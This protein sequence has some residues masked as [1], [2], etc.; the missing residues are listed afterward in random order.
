MLDLAPLGDR[1]QPST[2]GVDPLPPWRLRARVGVPGAWEYQEG[3]RQAADQLAGALAVAGRSP[4]QLRSVL[5]FG[6]GAGRV[7]PHFAARAPASDCVGCDVDQ[8]AIGWAVKWRPAQ[9]WLLSSFAPPLALEADG[10]DL[11]YSISVFSHLDRAAQDQWVEEL[12]RVLAPG[13]VALLSVHGAYAFE[14]FRTG[15]VTTRW[16]DPAAF[17]RASL[18]RDEFVYIPYRRS[19]WNAAEL[20]GVGRNYGLAFHGSEY[21]RASW[22]NELEVVEVLERALSDWQDV[23]VCVK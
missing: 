15:Q 6:C 2:E 16:C 10:F 23:V 7:L 18:G 20:P 12:A 14:Q 9:R 8:A 1:R 11:V 21:V 5:D 17:A 19:F 4:D 13:G 22:G 3:G